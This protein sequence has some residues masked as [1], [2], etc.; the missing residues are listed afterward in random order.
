MDYFSGKNYLRI[1]TLFIATLII[2]ASSACEH[3]DPLTPGNDPD[4]FT[5]IQTNIF[6][7]SCAL[8]GCHVGGPAPWGLDLSSSV[9]YDI[10]TNRNAGSSPSVPYVDPGNPDGSY[11]VQ[12]LEGAPTITVSRMPFGQPPLD[13]ALIQNIRDWISNGALDD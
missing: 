9:S 3:A 7:A 11:L 12:V 1:N 5:A 13:A 6:N 8:S 10:L 2:F 4:S